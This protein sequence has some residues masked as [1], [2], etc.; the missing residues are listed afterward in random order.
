MERIVLFFKKLMV[1]LTAA[2]IGFTPIA[3]GGDFPPS[4]AVQADDRDKY[5][6][7]A[8]DDKGTDTW[9]PCVIHGGYRYGPSMI[10]N[11]DGSIDLW[12]AS[13]G[14][15]DIIDLVS[16]K[17]LY[18]G[19]KRC[20]KEVIALKP[21]PETHDQMWTCDPGVIKIGE[22]YYIGYTTTD[23]PRGVNNDVCVARCKTPDGPFLEKWTGSGWGVEPAPIIRYTDNPERFGAGEPSFVVLDDTLYIYYS[24][25][26]DEATT[27]R[28]ATADATDENWPATIVEHGDCITGK[29]DAADSADVKYADEYGRFVAV[30][31]EK[32]FSDDSYVAVW[33]SF[34]GIHFRR[35]CAVKENTAAK[36][37]NC[38][39][40]GR[41]DGHIGAGDPVY[42]SYAY[43]GAGDGAWGKWSTRIH[44]VT[45]S[46]ADAPK[47]DPAGEKSS[48]VSVRRRS[49]RLIPEITTIKAEHQVYHIT[50]SEEIEIRAY[51]TDG[52]TIP[53]RSGVT[54]DGYDESIIRIEG[55]RI[56]AVSE[57]MTR[58]YAHW[59]GFTGDFVVHTETQS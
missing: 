44:R 24:W 37:H 48:S 25:V 53:I 26:N 45:L 27:T 7:I 35:C 5:L 18:D 34:D 49:V 2:G 46:L 55:S 41:A 31:T 9:Q 29:I 16:Y 4:D 39:I 43:G 50:E 10:L 28:V 22:Y 32:R 11:Q 13:N 17:R 56:Y 40:S 6:Q 36:L 58:V 19:G 23:D 12:S 8:A 33:E 20:T 15:G 57:G 38:G 1:W 59:H 21:T 3:G 14:P 30:Y 52:F 47:N 51:D 54:F 42:L